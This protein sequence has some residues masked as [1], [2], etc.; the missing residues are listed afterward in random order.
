MAVF[1]EVNEDSAEPSEETYLVSP[2]AL[3]AKTRK[4]L[5]AE[6]VGVVKVLMSISFRGV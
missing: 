5:R 2:Y 6:H 1:Q 3:A 4:T